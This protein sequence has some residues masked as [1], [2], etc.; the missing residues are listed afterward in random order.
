M[1]KIIV[2]LI[3]NGFKIVLAQVDKNF[4]VPGQNEGIPGY[5]HRKVFELRKYLD[6]PKDQMAIENGY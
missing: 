1:Y 3:G 5:K 4:V 6:S 2:I